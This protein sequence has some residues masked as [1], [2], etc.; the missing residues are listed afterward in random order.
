MASV[1]ASPQDCIFTDTI[2]NKTKLD[3]QPL[4]GK[5]L[6]FTD[7]QGF[8]YAYSI[9]ENRLPCFNQ[10]FPPEIKV[11]IGEYFEGNWPSPG[12]ECIFLEQFNNTNP[13]QPSYNQSSQIWT[14]PSFQSWPCWIADGY[15]PLSTDLY[16]KC[17]NTTQT[18]KIVDVI[19]V[20]NCEMKIVVDSKYACP[21]T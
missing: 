6:N 13:A 12:P 5:I 14:F 21:N 8:H 11:M 16:W 3:L 10:L 7:D 4:Y 19:Q 2:T 17:N 1:S 9:C 18:A 15:P 20:S